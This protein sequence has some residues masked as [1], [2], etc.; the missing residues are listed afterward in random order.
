M[1]S[2]NR[3]LVALVAAVSSLAAASILVVGFASS[4]AQ[5]GTCVE[6]G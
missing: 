5:A 6:M 2:V 3:R 4:P 1:W